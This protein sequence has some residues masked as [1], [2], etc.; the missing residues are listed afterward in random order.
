MCWPKSIIIPN[1]NCHILGINNYKETGVLFLSSILTLKPQYIYIYIY[2]K[3]KNQRGHIDSLLLWV[4]RLSACQTELSTWA[5]SDERL[6]DMLVLFDSFTYIYSALL[7]QHSALYA[8][9]DSTPTFI[10]IYIYIYI[11]TCIHTYI[12]IHNYIY[13]PYPS[14]YISYGNEK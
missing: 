7:P 2:N 11:H 6:S 13:S 12:Y 4:S 5:L 3:W 9:V 10:Y 8:K 1:F 14:L